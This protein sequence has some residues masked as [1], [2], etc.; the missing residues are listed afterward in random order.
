MNVESIYPSNIGWLQIKLNDDE[1]KHLW[2][3]CAEHK[4][5]AKPNLAGNIDN[6]Q[7]I[8]DKDNW[9]WN[10]VLLGCLNSYAKDFGN[11][12]DKYPTS[13]PHPYFL[14]SFWV[15]YQKET[16]FNPLHQHTNAIYSFVIWLKIPT[17]Y[18]DQKQLKIASNSNSESIS[19]F[20]FNYLDILGNNRGYIYKMSPSMEGTM[21]FFPSQLQHQ[22]FPF[23][24]CK[25]E[26]ISISGNIAVDTTRKF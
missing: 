25:E 20:S 18:E 11:V 13:I 17:K 2:N 22:V 8:I 3:C 24:N 10:N 19:N 7:D 23:Y 4:G 12:G 5:D 26:R 6:S 15:N 1:M 21:L 9:F 16:E 14:S